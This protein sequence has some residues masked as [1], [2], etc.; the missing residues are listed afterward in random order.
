MIILSLVFIYN[1]FTYFDTMQWQFDQRTDNSDLFFLLPL[2]LS[3]FFFLY[4]FQKLW[5]VQVF[6]EFLRFWCFYFLHFYSWQSHFACVFL[7]TV[8]RSFLGVAI[9]VF[10]YSKAFHEVME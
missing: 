6:L 9:P 7:F 2:I 1:S 4:I 8:N 10:V 5:D 3:P